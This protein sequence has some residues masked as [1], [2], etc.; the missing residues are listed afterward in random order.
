MPS[1]PKL[2][3]LQHMI[4]NVGN[5][6]DKLIQVGAVRLGPDNARSTY[7]GKLQVSV[8]EFARIAADFWI[9][10]DVEPE[11]CGSQIFIDLIGIKSTKVGWGTSHQKV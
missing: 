5:I 8:A 4:G 11:L 10:T 7:S 6:A 2:R 3:W 9:G 1:D